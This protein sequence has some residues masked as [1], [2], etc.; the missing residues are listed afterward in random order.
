V[1]DEVIALRRVQ[2]AWGGRK[3][4]RRLQDLGHVL[5]PSAST[6]TAILRRAQWLERAGQPVQPL[7]RFERAAPNEL[8]QMDYKGHFPTQAGARCHPLTVLEDHSRFNVVLAAEADQ[9]AATVQRALHAAFSL[10][11]LPEA[12]LCD[13][14]SPWGGP[15]PVC[16]YSTLGVWLLRRGG[17]L[18]QLCFGASNQ[19]QR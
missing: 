13:N 1:S 6:C 8:W 3:L 19:K 5:V 12:M 10:Y 16:P 2:P 15:E 7:Q 9:T 17:V 4:R 18:L 11:G 14:G